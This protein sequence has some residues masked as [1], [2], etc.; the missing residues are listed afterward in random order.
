MV[1]ENPDMQLYFPFRGICRACE[2]KKYFLDTEHCF[3]TRCI[4]D[5]IKD[6]LK[7]SV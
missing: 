7:D 2:R 3:C 1:N 4:T 6:S 5:F